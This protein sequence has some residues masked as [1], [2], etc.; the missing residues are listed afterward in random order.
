MKH[1]ITVFVFFTALIAVP[2]C[3][4]A[5][6]DLSAGDEAFQYGYYKT[7]ASYYTKAYGSSQS[8]MVAYKAAE[9]FRFSNDYRNAIKYYSIVVNSTVAGM[10]PN[11]EYYLATMFRNNGDADSALYYYQHYLRAANNEELE[12]RARQ[13]MRSCQWVLDS[14]SDTL[15]YT[16]THENANIN[17]EYSESGAVQLGDTLLIYS[18]MREINKPGTKDAIFSD[19]VL[20]QLFQSEFDAN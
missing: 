9:A 5:Q 10:Y 6:N 13:E 8:P 2:A 20:M 19:L 16:I 1:I 14:V 7:A 4:N 17:T 15:N 3:M 11:S 18:S 12:L